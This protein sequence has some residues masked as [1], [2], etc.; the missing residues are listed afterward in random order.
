MIFS[1]NDHIQQIINGTKTQTRRVYHPE[2]SREYKVGKT[3]SIQPARTKPGI[4]EGRIKVTRVWGEMYGFQISKDNAMAE[5]GYTPSEYEDL[6]RKIH[7]NWSF[8]QCIEFEFV[9]ICTQEAK[10]K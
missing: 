1:V 7:R 4:S 9:P 5:G 10:R 6:F 2:D 8:R 3:Y